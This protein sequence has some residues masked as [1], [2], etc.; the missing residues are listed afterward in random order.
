MTTPVNNNNAL[1]YNQTPALQNKKL[2]QQDFLRLMVAQV[3]HQDP[4]SP[5]TNGDFMGQ[6]AQFSTNDGINNMQQSLQQLALSLQSNETMQASTLVGH[7]V[8]VNSDKL[9]LEGESPAKA[10][11]EV[12]AGMKNLKAS[13]YSASG[14]LI[15]TIDL[16]QPPEGMHHFSWDGFDDKGVKMAEGNYS[17]KLQGSYQGQEYSLPVMSNAKVESVRISQYGEGV[18]L[19]VSGIGEVSL[20]DVRQIENA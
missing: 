3:Q 14:A 20:N 2:G 1:G 15:R 11:V 7:H 4:M 6:L 13:I 18:I 19:K 9:H 8:L 12:P 10:A 16:G 5:Q 17:I